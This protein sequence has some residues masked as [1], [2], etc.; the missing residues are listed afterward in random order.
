MKAGVDRKGE[1]QNVAIKRNRFFHAFERERGA[2]IV[3]I[4]RFRNVRFGRLAGL[5][6]FI[7]EAV[8]IVHHHGA[9][10]V[11]R[12]LRIHGPGTGGGHL[13]AAVLD[14]IECLVDV[15]YLYR[16]TGDAGVVKMLLERLL[17]DPRELNQQKLE[18]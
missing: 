10:S 17:F 16:K 4:A 9:R 18:V 3:D 7:Y 12:T 5:H 6:E 1:T 14:F 15:P 2:R 8:G 13:N 11:P